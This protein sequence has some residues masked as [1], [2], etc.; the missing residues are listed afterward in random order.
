MRLDY[1]TQDYHLHIVHTN[2]LSW[3]IFFSKKMTLLNRISWTTEDIKDIVKRMS[4]NVWKLYF[5]RHFKK[6]T[7]EITFGQSKIL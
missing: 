7:I 1:K 3:T 2:L 4:C 5:K 6:W